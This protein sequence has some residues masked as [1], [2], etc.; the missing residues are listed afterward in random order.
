MDEYCTPGGSPAASDARC[1]AFNAQLRVTYA[2][3]SQQVVSTQPGHG[4]TGTT[5]HNP[6][7]YSHI[8]HGEKRDDRLLQPGWDEPGFGAAPQGWEPAE[9][10]PMAGNLGS[11]DLH[12]MPPIGPAAV[13]QPVSRKPL[14]PEGGGAQE[15]WL[16]DFGVNIAGFARLNVT[17][18]VPP[19]SES[20]IQMKHAETANVH[21]VVNAYCGGQSPCVVDDY[22]FNNANQTNELTLRNGV[23]NHTFT[24][25]SAC[26]CSSSLCIF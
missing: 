4:W 12:E 11:L 7:T 3:G 26:K 15:R 9:A 16:F 2:D 22:T 6:V 24:P 1:R 8:Y 23:P 5:T 10:W 14:D 20:V 19:G 18:L 13:L 21:G 25:F 17:A